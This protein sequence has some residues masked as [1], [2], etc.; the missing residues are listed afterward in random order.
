MEYNEVIII[1][2]TGLLDVDYNNALQYMEKVVNANNIQFELRCLISIDNI[3]NEKWNAD[4]YSRHGN[5]FQSYWFQ[6]RSSQ[7]PIKKQPSRH[8][9][10][11][12][13]Y[14]FVYVNSKVLLYISSL[15]MR[16]PFSS[17]ILAKGLTS[18]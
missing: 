18:N 10:I 9:E 16:V 15:F 6:S 17:N 4:V 8:L 11:G 5:Q 3:N 2:S 12:N 1:S 7:Y 14:T 13:E